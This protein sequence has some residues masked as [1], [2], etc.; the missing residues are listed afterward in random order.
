MIIED[1]Q[2][3]VE[4]G[5]AGAFGC[6]IGVDRGNHGA[7]LR[8]AGADFVVDDISM[9]TISGSI[10]TRQQREPPN[11]LVHFE[12]IGRMAKARHTALFF[13]YDGTLTPIVARPDLAV[14]SEE[15]RNALRDSSL[16]C[17]VSIISGRARHDVQALVGLDNLYYAGSH[18]FDVSGPEGQRLHHK[19]GSEF[20][21]DL[22]Q[23]EHELRIELSGIDGALVEGKTYAVA[24]HYRLVAPKDR[25]RFHSQFS[26]VAARHPELRVTRGKMVM[27]LRPGVDWDKGKVVQWLLESLNLGTDDVLPFY[28]GDDRTDEDAFEVLK[29]IG[30]GI[31][32]GEPGHHTAAQYLLRDPA[33]VLEFIERLTDRLRVAS[34]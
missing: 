20:I 19:P 27:E 32:V 11:A 13:D 25:A 5:R 23:A 15:M 2:A 26:R 29:D 22:T 12:D 17:T 10:A 7:A 24:A 6:V 28:F 21:P 31:F 14:M 4:A 1:A 3:G 34:A 30:I 16:F 8:R 18:G 33:E 9:L